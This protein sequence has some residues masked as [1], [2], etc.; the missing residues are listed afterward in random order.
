MKVVFF[1]T[2]N[3]DKQ[4]LAGTLK[5]YPDISAEYITEVLSSTNIAAAKD[6]QIIS[7]FINSEIKKE[8]I[9]SLPNLKLIAT[10]SAGYDQID[11]AYAKKKGV[12]VCNIPA[13]GSRT[14]AEFTFAL[15]LCLSRKVMAANE[16]IK[17]KH[18]FNFS[19]FKG[20]NLQGKTLGVI[21]TGRIGQNVMQI[22]KGFGMKI[23]GFDAHP[24]SQKALEMDFKYAEL[25]ELLAASDIITL[26]V[27]YLKETHHLINSENISKIKKGALLI[28]TA[29][30]EV[31]ETAALLKGL[32]QGI[33]SGAGLDVLENERKMKE[34]VELLSHYEKNNGHPDVQEIKTIL[35]NHILINLPQVIITP[36]IAFYTQEAKDEILKI[37]VENIVNFT[38]GKNNYNQVK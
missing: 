34:E 19:H 35:E 25:D 4:E 21:G 22:A 18:D 32:K 12:N 38:A 23:L 24:D 29:R 26:H 17:S 20:F 28:N 6:A 31:V 2:D 5:N 7:V 8:Q 9:D 33:L 13:Y 14:V 27:P 15:I 11:I 3:E 36:H 1:E 30:G 16:Q 37:A 10:R